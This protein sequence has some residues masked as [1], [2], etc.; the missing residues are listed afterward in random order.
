MKTF[1]GKG[2]SADST[3]QK[4]FSSWEHREHLDFIL[5]CNSCTM[6]ICARGNTYRTALGSTITI[7]MQISMVQVRYARV[8]GKLPISHLTQQKCIDHTTLPNMN[9]I[10]E[11]WLNFARMYWIPWSVSAVRANMTLSNL[12]DCNA[13]CSIDEWL[14]GSLPVAS[15]CRRQSKQLEAVI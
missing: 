10:I 2:E 6:D 8:T 9:I 14:I 11:M 12:I 15:G 1:P 7:H 3:S 4:N 5:T 13:C